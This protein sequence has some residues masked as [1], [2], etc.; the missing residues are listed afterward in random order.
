MTMARA[1]QRRR[2]A[3]GT[4]GAVPGG[5]IAL[6]AAV[7]AVP[8]ERPDPAVPADAAVLELLELLELP[9]VVKGREEVMGGTVG[10]V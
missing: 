4:A 3:A 1:T 2:S 10:A 5:G 7:R 8:A 6:A 9:A